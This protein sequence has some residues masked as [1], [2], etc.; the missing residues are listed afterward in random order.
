MSNDICSKS[1]ICMPRVLSPSQGKQLFVAGFL[2]VEKIKTQKSG[3][4]LNKL[5]AVRLLQK[6]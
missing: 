3:G 6:S 5:A 2:D 4:T 1:L